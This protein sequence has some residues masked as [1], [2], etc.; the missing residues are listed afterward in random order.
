MIQND[1]GL[2]TGF[3]EA[4]KAIYLIGLIGNVISDVRL[5]RSLKRER[6]VNNTKQPEDT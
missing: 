3:R 6:D 4:P 5:K 2:Q 1:S